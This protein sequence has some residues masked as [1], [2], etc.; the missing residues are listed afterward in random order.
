M[1]TT[2]IAALLAILVTAAPAA[3]LDAEAA[4]PYRWRV[5]VRFDAH[6]LFTADYRARVVKDLAAALAPLV[7][8]VGAVDVAE[9]AGA[10]D[11]FG[12]AL[13]EK[14]FAAFDDPRFRD[15]SGTRSQFPLTP[16]KVHLLRVSVAA[17]GGIDLSARQLDGLSG[18]A[19]PAVRAMRAGG[20]ETVARTA[21]LLVGREFGPAG[22]FD[23]DPT[24]PD[25]VTVR[26]Q[27]GSL[28]GFDRLVSSGDVLAVSVV[29]RGADGALVGVPFDG[30]LLRVEGPARGG[31]ARCRVLTRYAR[32][33]PVGPAVVGLRCVKLATVQATVE[34]RVVDPAGNPPPAGTLI[35]VRGSDV[36][37]LPRS[38]GRDRLEFRGGAFF[39]PRPLR[40]VACLVVSVGT[41]GEERFPVPV[42]GTGLVVIKYEADAAKQRLALVERARDDLR[43]RVIDAKAAGTSLTRELTRM[44]DASKNPEALDR[45]TKGLEA[46]A[47]TDA[48]L[49][50]ELEAFK[51]LAGADKPATDAAAQLAQEIAGLGA[52]RPDIESRAAELRAVIAKSSDPRQFEKEF[53]RKDLAARVRAALALGEVPDAI[54]LLDQLFALTADAKLNEQ[55]AKL[56]EEWKPRS[57][58]HAR[59]RDYVLGPW[60]LVA[61]LEDFPGAAEKLADAA[62]VL[63]AA[64]DRYGL[65]NLIG[66][67]EGAYGR[68]KEISDGLKP[69]DQAQ[70]KMVK[71]LFDRL[72]EVQLNAT[73]KVAALEGAAKP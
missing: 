54:E 62:K 16:T 31:E 15:R 10:D 72:R 56:A 41:V 3:A 67:I 19:T 69:E 63:T 64:D 45:A 46:L 14:G 38:D 13:A 36:D 25:E 66:A 17:G 34:V 23:P 29:R 59:A 57:P 9:A 58:E 28:P 50:R 40:G 18:L 26:F 68:L 43:N 53:R 1:P 51:K 8:G 2:P 48:A 30:T 27:G 55:K 71:G 33:F 47:A 12:R 32:P 70:L 5:V 39:S 24:R 73:G 42:T 22:T 65:R 11:A 44:I 49:G 60:R 52:I 61:K 20:F 4:R 21:G 6:P 37:F 35:Q 7:S